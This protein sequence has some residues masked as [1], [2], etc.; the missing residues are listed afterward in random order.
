MG[1]TSEQ[2]SD[3]EWD[4]SPTHQVTLS[5][6]F[7]MMKSEVTQGVY[8][9]V[10]GNNPSLFS[11]SNRPVETVSWY[12]A[13]EFANAL[14]NQQG[15]VECYNISG[16]SVN[17]SNPNC[18]GWRLPTEA[19]WEYVARGGESYKYAGSNAV[20]Y[21]AWYSSNSSGQTHDVCGKNR[22]GYGLCDMS[23]NVSEWVWDWKGSY[24][25][26]PT[27]DPW[28]LISGSYRVFRGGGLYSLISL[29][30][31]IATKEPRRVRTAI[32][33]FV[34]VVSLN[35]ARQQVSTPCQ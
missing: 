11:G 22:N 23:G 32:W 14:S 31:R 25:N 7:Y 34:S 15:L 26:S 21:V 2:G 8:Q 35:L 19:E 27:V 6:D 18:T 20:A 16:N 33:V 12:D 1:C 29:G 30:C 13:V 10:M 3:C 4:E 17:W 28:E 5:T 9:Q 24:T